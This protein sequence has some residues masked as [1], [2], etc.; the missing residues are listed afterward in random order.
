[1]RGDAFG[2]IVE[3][4]ANHCLVGTKIYEAY[5][6]FINGN[7]VILIMATEKGNIGPPPTI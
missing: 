6:V 2:G 1:M 4:H 7:A 3:K 5:L